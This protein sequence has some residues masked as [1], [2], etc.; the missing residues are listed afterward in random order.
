M[1]QRPRRAIFGGRRTATEDLKD[2]NEDG[3]RGF[4]DT[5]LGDLL[6]ADGKVGVQGP[7][8]RES[9]R[10]ARR[11]ESST[12]NA[13]GGSTARSE[14]RAEIARE[15]AAAEPEVRGAP[16]P[17]VTV[18]NLPPSN[19]GRGDGMAEARRRRDDELLRRAAEAIRRAEEGPLTINGYTWNQIQAMP[20]AMTRI[21]S[22]VPAY[23]TRD[24]FTAAALEERRNRNRLRANPTS[25]EAVGYESAAAAAGAYNKPDSAP[26]YAEYYTSA[27]VTEIPE[28]TEENLRGDRRRRRSGYAKG[29]LVQKRQTKTRSKS[30]HTDMRKEGLFK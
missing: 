7:G 20:N 17:E 23:P 19:I 11:G 24:E 4:G 9:R 26:N 3:K 27:P 10:G 8:L 30:N 14:R 6:G 5:W 15:R 25:P 12:S 13:G 29:G 2:I 18:T 16:V 22:G 1:A 21:R 28:V